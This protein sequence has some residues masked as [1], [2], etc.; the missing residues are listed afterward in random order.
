M[1]GVRKPLH[2]E[3]MRNNESGHSICV[4]LATFGS[5]DDRDFVLRSG[6]D[7]AGNKLKMQKIVWVRT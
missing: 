2:V 6:V 7:V 3:T 4:I 5:E 1:A